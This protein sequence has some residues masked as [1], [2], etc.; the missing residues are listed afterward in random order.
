MKR[1]V[2]IAVLV[3]LLTVLLCGCSNTLTAE[4]V[5]AVD[6]NIFEIVLDE[7]P[8]TGF[9]WTYQ[10][11]DEDI[12]QFVSDEYIEPDNQELAGAGGTHKWVFEGIK[13]GDAEITFSYAR[14]SEDNDP[15]QTIVYKYSIIDGV[16]VLVDKIDSNDNN[17]N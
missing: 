15:A 3:V 14:S 12:I 4:T 6:P 10:I 8:T 9:T 5:E 16:A 2:F 11:S 1:F 13:D 7:N 17:E